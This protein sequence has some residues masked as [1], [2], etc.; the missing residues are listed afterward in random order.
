M[1]I[2]V[3]SDTHDNLITLKKAIKIFEENKVEMI[4]HCGDW[5]APFTMEFLANNVTVPIKGVFGNN[6]GDI[7]R[8]VDRNA[9]VK[10]PI[11]FPERGESLALQVEDRKII[12][13]HGDDENI[14]QAFI[15]SHLYDIVLTGHTH[16]VRNELVNDVL[17]VNPGTTCYA[18]GKGIINF[19]SVAILDTS[20]KSAKI[21]TF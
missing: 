13:Y 12:V 15:A 10:N 2:G 21:I 9:E 18:T 1:L 8:A 14:L 20:S 5:V 19:A 17:V 16:E 11:T 4:I 7:K 6:K 3:I